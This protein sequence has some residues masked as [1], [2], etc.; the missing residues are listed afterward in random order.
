VKL[1]SWNVNSIRARLGRLEAWLDLHQPDVV[2]LQETQVD[3]RRFPRAALEQRGYELLIHGTGGNGGV[4]IG[5]RVGLDDPII[6]IPGA[7]AP[8]REPRL[9]SATCGG[10]RVH[11]VYAPNGRKVGTPPHEVKLAWFALLGAWLEIDGLGDVPTMVLGDLNIAP[12]DIDI[13]EPHRYRK[14]NL[15]SPRERAA[16]E[17]LIDGGLVDCIRSQFGDEHV[18]T[19]WN[20]RSDFYASD[21]GWRLDHVL[22]DPDTAERVRTIVVDRGER[23]ITGS[24]DHAP[25]LVTLH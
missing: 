24:S 9:L 18:F 17:A 6:G 16:F 15:T 7:K 10:I 12:L 19:W 20:R 21:R 23:G 14:R 3:D 8:F 22:A 1:A 13:W 11:T 4:A 25:I 5:T 2:C